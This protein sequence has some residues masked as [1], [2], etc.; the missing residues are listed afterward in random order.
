MLVQLPSH[1]FQN[2]GTK[3]SRMH[4][5]INISAYLVKEIALPDFFAGKIRT[6]LLKHMSRLVIKGFKIGHHQI[7]LCC[8]QIGNQII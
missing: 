8:P 6:H 5:N 4:I 2:I 3:G 1:S 7:L